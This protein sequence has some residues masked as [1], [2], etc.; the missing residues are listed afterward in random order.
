[1]CALALMAACSQTKTTSA[2]HIPHLQKR[3]AATQ[4]IVDGKPYLALA[5]EMTNTASSSPQYMNTVWPNLVKMHLNTVLAAVA[6]DWIEPAEGKVDFTLADRL[7]QD[8]RSHHMRLVFLWFASWKNGLSS[9]V[10]VWVKA[11]QERF[12]RAQVKGG[13]TV[14]VLSTLSEANREADS[15]AFAAF[16]RHVRDVDSRAHTVI[17]I[18]VENE[19]GLLGDSRDRSPAANE[20]FAK[21]V[22]PELM[23]YLRNHKDSLLP[24]FRRLWEAAGF[25]TSGSW[26][27]VFGKGP[28]A[29][30]VF[31]GWNYARYVGRVAGAGK[32]EYPIPMFVNAWRV[33]P[34]D[35][36][37]GDYPSGG[38]QAHMHDLWRAGAPQID[39]LSLDVQ[40]LKFPEVVA[41][42]TRSGNPLFIPES[43]GDAVGAAN[44]F[45]AVG[46]H[47]AIGYSVFGLDL[48]TRLLGSGPGTGVTPQVPLDIESLPL[49]R[50]YAV[51]S[52][53]A[54]LILEHQ[55][56]GTI[57]AAWLAQENADQ[58]IQLGD[59]TLNVELTRDRRTPNVLP[60]RG[61]GIF[62]SVGPD[63]YV[64]AGN[65]VQVTFSP[66]TPGPEIA[67]LA[68]VEAGTYVDGRWIPGRRLAADDCVL[69]YD[70][71]A[72]AS[73][74]QSGSGVRFRGDGPSIQHVKL[75]RYR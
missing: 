29:E 67:G 62:I 30:E 45:Y 40:S 49:P 17:M 6:W 58:K 34:Q 3:G 41:Q 75:Y 11:N 68:S 32:A 53:L 14:E 9:F 12:P 36:T 16:M 2:L 5:G 31:M 1:M 33:Q 26:E 4:L 65:D 46:Q 19:V 66:N 8:A 57:A 47:N 18:Q 10:P 50:S 61:Y 28:A 63:E 56:K 73:V 7:I 51:L 21:S 74:N 43:R 52:Q 35:K 38:P 70:L 37:P 20:A 22:P 39:I 27:E 55:G 69:R 59:Y 54:P 64:I 24:E 60:E 25:K 48:T 23:D 44:V 72:A 42:Y 71:A 13:K 15:R